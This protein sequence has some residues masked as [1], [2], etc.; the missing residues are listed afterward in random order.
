M[1]LPEDWYHRA[2]AYPYAAPEHSYLWRD[3][4]VLPFDPGSTEGRAP[5]LA[6]G[7]NRAPERLSQKFAHLGSHTIPVERAWLQDFDVVYAA[8]ITRYG[9]VPAMLQHAPGTRVEIAITWL[10][11]AQL[12]IMHA[13]E[14]TAANYVYARLGNIVLE[15]DSSSHHTSALCYVGD[16]GHLHEGDGHAL[17]LAAVRAEGR[18]REGVT[19]ETVLKRLHQRTE[20]DQDFEGF[21]LALIQSAETRLAFTQSLASTST[22][23]AYPH[24]VLASGK[25]IAGQTA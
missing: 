5:V 6:F 15:G 25:D 16:R 17:P 24:T 7:S 21:L 3:R 2:T 18:P 22:P 23:F 9:A 12:P 1:S 14:M 10:D 20:K 11:A 8:H 4:E 19:T 13:S